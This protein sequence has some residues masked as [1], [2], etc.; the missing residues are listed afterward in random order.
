MP[1]RKIQ[2]DKYKSNYLTNVILNIRLPKVLEL[3]NGKSPSDF[4]K[5]IVDIFPS[6]REI[7]GDI[8][9][10]SGKT[11]KQEKRVGWEFINK[12]K[13][14]R[15]F[16][17]PETL[18]IEFNKYSTFED[19]FDT[20]NLIFTTL[21]ELY[22]IKIVQGVSLRYINQ[23]F[24]ESGNPYNWGR[25]IKKSLFNFPIDFFEGDVKP[26]RYLN[27][28][29]FKENDYTIHFVYGLFNSEYPSQINR[30]EFVLDYRCYM[31]EDIE[32]S[33]V[34]EKIKEFHEIE[35]R[36]FEKSILQPLR[37]KMGVFKNGK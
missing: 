21:I 8:F 33:I 3:S 23:I 9:E 34:L 31:H 27:S 35:G 16:L 24:F 17:E 11:F 10:I 20:V 32:T 7:P 2:R 30:K 26:L 4:Q 36:W 15:I 37:E 25:Y 14:R 6:I 28:L 19:F 12:E 22:P 5:K 29:D 1:Q 18:E 13:T